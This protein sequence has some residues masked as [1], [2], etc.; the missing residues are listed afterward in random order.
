M[1]RL[2][3]HLLAQASRIKAAPYRS[4]VAFMDQIAAQYDFGDQALLH[5]TERLKDVV[6]PAGILSPG[7]QGI[8]G[9]VG[10]NKFFGRPGGISSAPLELD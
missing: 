2:F 5:L 8:W 3:P 1:T 9:P 10:R 4:H 6:D 7:K